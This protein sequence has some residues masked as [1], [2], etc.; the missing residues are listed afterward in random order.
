MFQP[1]ELGEHLAPHLGRELATA[2]VALPPRSRHTRTPATTGCRRV[3]R[4][5]ELA[6]RLAASLESRSGNDDA[7]EGCLCHTFEWRSCLPVRAAE[8]AR[9]ALG[10]IREERVLGAGISTDRLFGDRT[11]SSVDVT[12]M[13]FTAAPSGAHS[14]TGATLDDLQRLSRYFPKCACSACKAENQNLRLVATSRRFKS[15]CAGAILQVD[16]GVYGA[17]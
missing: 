3:W 13:T 8:P 4:R 12:A 14:S 16:N 6:S 17:D 1:I 5:P 2:S 7:C 11:K 10:K 15:G 9:I